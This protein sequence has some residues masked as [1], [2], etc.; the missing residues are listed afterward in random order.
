M[1]PRYPMEAFA[2]AMVVF[3]QN[4]RY[5]I[6]VGILIIFITTLGLFLDKHIGSGIPN[7]SRIPC[8][9]ILM[10]AL[11]YSIFQI[12]L[13]AV[14]GYELQ[15]T[16]YI[17]H[18]FIGI[19]ISKHII[20][21]KGNSDFNLLLLECAGAYATL[22]IISIIREFMTGGAIYGFK[23]ADIGF[24]SSGFS[25]VI[26]GYILAAIGMA[27]LN[28]IYKS[29]GHFPK[30]DALFVIIPV[31]LVIQPFAIDSISPWASSIITIA[32]A[33]ILYYS[34]KR[35]LVFSRISKDFMNRPIELLSM[36]IIY[37]TLSMF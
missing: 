36:G 14:L 27:I 2:L 32:I 24:K 8:N 9:I 35:Y 25:N 21:S 33:L 29:E 18:I 19:L 7:W 22:I 26:M 28:Y 6:I 37:M 10:L 23:M 12:V 15:S 13:I 1:K 5:A 17:I 20:D 30:A 11:T 4:M 34:V 16:D 3:S 31:V